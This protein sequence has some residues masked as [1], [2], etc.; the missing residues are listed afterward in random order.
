MILLAV[1]VFV[2]ALVLLVVFGGLVYG[3]WWL[4]RH[5]NLPS[6]LQVAQVYLALGQSY[7]ELAMQ[8]VLKPILL[9]HTVLATVRG[10]VGAI[11]EFASAKGRG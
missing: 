4:Q 1:E 10:W 11:V 2:M 7:V 5:E 3:L 8:T 6:W 9:I